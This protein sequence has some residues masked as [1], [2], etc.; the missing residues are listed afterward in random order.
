MR[1]TRIIT[2]LTTIN[3]IS[4]A[5][6]NHDHHNQHHLQYRC[7]SSLSAYFKTQPARTLPGRLC[8]GADIL[9][10]L[11]G[12]TTEGRGEAGSFKSDE[13]RL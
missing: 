8:P 10:C 7:P 2:D 5:I 3:I 11:P 9:R 1:R 13:M 4:S 6:I 12:I